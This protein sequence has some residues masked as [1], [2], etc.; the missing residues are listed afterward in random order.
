MSSALSHVRTCNRS[1]VHR[2]VHAC[3]STRIRSVS[4]GH[5]SSLLRSV[6]GRR[7]RV[8]LVHQRSIARA[9]HR[10]APR[11]RS[12]SKYL[13]SPRVTHEPLTHTR[14]VHHVSNRGHRDSVPAVQ[15]PDGETRSLR[16]SRSPSRPQ[17]W[18]MY[19]VHPTRRTR[20]DERPV[21][22]LNG[23]A[24]GTRGFRSSCKQ[25][26]VQCGTGVP[27]RTLCG[28][29]RSGSISPTRAMPLAPLRGS[30]FVA[31]R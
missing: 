29:L 16:I 9:T 18:D 6:G 8:A 10:G 14:R 27:P 31:P 1:C 15:R 23:D 30:S 17:P 7:R 22:K 2:T 19:V 20:T 11:S 24:N 25:R 12:R 26:P 28:R 5:W 21:R 3:R 13:Y 4:A